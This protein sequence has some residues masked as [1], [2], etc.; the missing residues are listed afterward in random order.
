M[1]K[2]SNISQILVQLMKKRK[3]SM[4]TLAKESEI[5]LST[6]ASYASAKKSSYSSDHLI[7]LS[8]VLEVSLDYLLTGEDRQQ[9]DLENLPLE[10][11]FSGYFKVKIEKLKIPEKDEKE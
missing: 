8:E 1:K 10:K 2:H 3:M 6:L 11:L 4:R 7:R 5:P 9:I